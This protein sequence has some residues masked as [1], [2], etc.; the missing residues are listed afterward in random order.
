MKSL[1]NAQLKKLAMITMLI[2]HI[3]AILIEKTSLYYVNG[4]SA[5]DLILRTIGRLAF[6]IFC[7]LLVQGFIHTS[8]IRKYVIRLSLFAICSELP[9]DLAVSNGLSF[10]HQNVGFT[11]TIGILMLCAYKWFENRKEKPLLGYLLCTTVACVTAYFLSVDYSY[12]GILLITILYLLRH[13][14]KTKC[15]LGALLFTY[16]WTAVLAFPLIYNSSGEKG[17]SR[18]TGRAFYLFYPVHLLILYFIKIMI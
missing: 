7:Y 1:D 17:T 2:D 6:P 13:D 14:N 5:I 4:F 18:I 8:N 11:L 9:F 15:I 3:G 16:Q 12:Q 10:E